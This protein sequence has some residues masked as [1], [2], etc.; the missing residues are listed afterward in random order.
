MAKIFKKFF[1]SLTSPFSNRKGERSAF[2]SRSLLFAIL[3]LFFGWLYF[4]STHPTLPTP[5]APLHFYSNQTRHDIKLL[6]S[7]ALRQAQHAIDIQMYGVTDPNIL[8]LLHQKALEGV[9]ISIEYDKKA[10]SQKLLKTL[11]ASVTISASQAK[12]LMHKKILIIDEGT[13]FLGSANL[14]PASLRHHDN[15]VIGLHCPPLAAFLRSPD[16]PSFSFSS[17][18]V[19]GKIWLL[20]DQNLQALQQLINLLD[21]A[22]KTIRIAMFTF[23]H[24]QLADALIAAHQRGVLVEVAIDRYTARGASEKCLSRLKESGINIFI[25]QGQQLL[26]HKWALIDDRAFAMGSANWTKA[27]FQKNED[28]LLIFPHLDESKIKFL[29]RLWKNISLESFN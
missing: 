8:S 15:L 21:S 27:A 10:S 5:S 23:T 19:E 13:L 20:P 2:P 14:T 24:P 1:K 7:T 18:G 6:F 9:P 16:T 29:K 3:F 12:G 22:Q 28:F 11:P 25:N 26:H 4:A 17:P